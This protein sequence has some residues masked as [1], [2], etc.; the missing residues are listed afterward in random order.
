[1]FKNVPEKNKEK[2]S[3]PFEPF[4]AIQNLKFSL[5]ANNGCRH[6]FETLKSR[7]PNYFSAAVTLYFKTLVKNGPSQAN[8]YDA[9]NEK[10]QR[11]LKIKKGVLIDQL[12]GDVPPQDFFA[13]NQIIFL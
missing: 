3:K 12:K 7:L 8:K 13:E 9:C 1:M 2:I 10:F 11:L 6:F 4:Q 5:W